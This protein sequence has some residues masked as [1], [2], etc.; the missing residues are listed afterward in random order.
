MKENE[1]GILSKR[2]FSRFIGHLLVLFLS[3]F[4]SE[5]GRLE[6]FGVSQ[7]YAYNAGSAFTENE[8][9]QW[10]TQKAVQYLLQKERGRCQ[11]IPRGFDRPF[12][13]FHEDGCVEGG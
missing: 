13:G 5:P 3:L 1:S 10:I 11:T 8:V 9:H 4:G 7:T 2:C 6:L 12:S